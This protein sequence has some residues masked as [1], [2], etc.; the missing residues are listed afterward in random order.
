[1]KLTK[2]PPSEVLRIVV[3]A[4]EPYVEGVSAEAL[5]TALR[6]DAAEAEKTLTCKDVQRILGVSR[7]TVM[8]M[9]REGMLKRLG[10]GRSVRFDPA[11]IKALVG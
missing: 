10:M 9:A 3:Q 11:S 6:G 8:K 5:V 7:P 2:T 4:L 1:M